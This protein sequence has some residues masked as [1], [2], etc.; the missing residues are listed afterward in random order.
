M[1]TTFCGTLPHGDREKIRTQ[2][3]LHSKTRTIGV[4][5]EGIAS[6]L[7]ERERRAHTAAQIAANER[8]EARAIGKL[9]DTAEAR[10][11]EIKRSSLKGLT[12]TWDQQRDLTHTREWDLNDPQRITKD[13]LPRNTGPVWETQDFAP[14]SSLQVFDCELLDD[15]AIP[16][17]KRA[18]LI[19]G[20][21]EGAAE[22]A[23]RRSSE[24]QADDI[25]ASQAET[26]RR[27]ADTVGAAQADSAALG[28]MITRSD[29]EALAAAANRKA[30]GLRAAQEAA[31][32]RQLEA[33]MSDPMLREDTRS[34]VH[35]NNQ[36]RFR[37]DH[38]KGLS[39]AQLADIRD[40]QQQQMDA[41]ATRR[42]MDLQQ[43]QHED[44]RAL[45][46]DGA[47][48]ALQEE[49]E[50]V[51]ASQLA[52]YYA[53]LKRMASDKRA[54]DAEQ[55]AREISRQRVCDSGLLSQF[56]TSLK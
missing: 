8:D 54:A 36:N 26:L 19:E 33:I 12:S 25:T 23:R 22:L 43:K 46:Y 14:S 45:A 27:L 47:A 34:S 52:G 38:F 17:R 31:D 39:A 24:K 28:R 5:V 29:N 50:R 10:G 7:R 42:A 13:T 44:A 53:D 15:P 40:T 4:D 37:P 56:G 51:R 55:R 16:I 35:T 9:V 2:A 41:A 3:F 6:Q 20:L 21:D 11:G 30:E 18:A 1:S 49:A 32:T 48:S